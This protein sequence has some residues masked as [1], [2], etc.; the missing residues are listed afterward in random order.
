MG[1][2]E[3]P[4]V[5]QIREIQD[6]TEDVR[7]LFFD[8]DLN[9]K[10]GQ[11]ILL[12]IPG[13]DEKPF[14]V[15][16]Q[17]E[18]GFGLTIA[19]VGKF[20]DRLFRLKAGDKI[21]IRGPYGSSFTFRGKNL[22]L[23]A[24]G[25]GI[26]PLNFFFQEARANNFNV[27]IVMG[28]RTGDNAV[29]F[30]RFETPQLYH[31]YDALLSTDDGSAGHKGFSTDL[32]EKTLGNKNIDTVY[33]CGPEKM[34]ERVIRITDSFGVGCQV[35]LERYMKCAIGICGQCCIDPSGA[36]VCVEGPVFDKEQVREFIEFGK[37]KR[38][39]SG[40]RVSL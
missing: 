7:T 40:R 5:V 26:A 31:E 38:D 12:W 24:G 18:I 17:N 10:P 16:S 20:T 13:C 33:T 6:E 22:L 35:S 8:Y 27:D 21:G 3:R 32:L 36:R 28:A 2:L 25:M 39:K 37:Y 30:K 11:F 15:S 1:R 23:V 9:A 34:L 4:E 19:K 14:S 29:F